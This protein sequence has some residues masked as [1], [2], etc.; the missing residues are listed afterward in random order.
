MIKCNAHPHRGGVKVLGGPQNANAEPNAV[1]ISEL[2]R[3]V[4]KDLVALVVDKCAV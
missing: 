1:A 3:L 2:S 4:T